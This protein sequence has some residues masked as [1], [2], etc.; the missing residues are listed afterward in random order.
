MMVV[1]MET[2]SLTGRPSMVPATILLER[3]LLEPELLERRLLEP[4]LLE[5][6]LPEPHS[7]EALDLECLD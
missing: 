3:R 4:E 1:M 5:R 2:V 7:A 6:R